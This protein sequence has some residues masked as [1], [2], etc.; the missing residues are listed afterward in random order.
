MCHDIT[1]T[2]NYLQE[3]ETS[4][5]EHHRIKSFFQETSYRD[6]IDMVVDFGVEKGW[7][8]PTACTKIAF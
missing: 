7:V 4:P 6:A 8:N 3:P 2:K 1:H 5:R